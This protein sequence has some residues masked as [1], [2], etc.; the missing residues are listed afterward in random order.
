MSTFGAKVRLISDAFSLSFVYSPKSRVSV[1][2]VVQ[3]S[4]QGDAWVP[5]HRSVYSTFDLFPVNNELI[6]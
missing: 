4:G 1:L 2:H 5:S 6:Y 3:G